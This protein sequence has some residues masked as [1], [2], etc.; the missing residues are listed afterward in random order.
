MTNLNRKLLDLF[1]ACDGLLF[2]DETAL[3]EISKSQEALKIW[4]KDSIQGLI[5]MG[6]FF[7]ICQF[8]IKRI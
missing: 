1:Q 3:P 6:N 7:R 5:L 8:E 2:L 4:N